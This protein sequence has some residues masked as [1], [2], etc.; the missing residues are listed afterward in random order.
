MGSR[1]SVLSQ[2][3][4]ASISELKGVWSKG[5]QV[6]SKTLLVPPRMAINSFS[7]GVFVPY[8]KGKLFDVLV[9]RGMV[10]RV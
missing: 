2:G 3:L 4:T 1:T 9:R 5:K 10:N 7:T 8:K 6:N